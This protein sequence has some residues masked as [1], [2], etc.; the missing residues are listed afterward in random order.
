MTTHIGGDSYQVQ[1]AEDLTGAK[2]RCINLAGTIAQAT[3]K[4]GVG[5]LTTYTE[6]GYNATAFIRGIHK[7][8]VGGAV[9]TVGYPLKVANSGWLVVATSGD[10]FVA[11]ALA[12]AAS[13]DI[14]PVLF[15]GFA[16]SPVTLL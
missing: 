1:A 11:R 8:Y 12:T 5:I 4:K 9:S 15:D 14:C 7:A 3:E 2:L 10:G 13:G 6:S 16:L